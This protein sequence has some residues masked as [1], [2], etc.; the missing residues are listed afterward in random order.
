MKILN[1]IYNLITHP[2]LI[3]AINI[4]FFISILIDVYTD[5]VDLVTIL[6]MLFILLD[7]LVDIRN[8]SLRE[9]NI[10]LESKNEKTR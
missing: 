3:K 7:T 2:Y 9:I 6:L 10:Y 8:N 5:K 1:K 4:L